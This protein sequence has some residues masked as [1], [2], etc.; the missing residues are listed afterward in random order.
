VV[1]SLERYQHLE[2]GVD[3]LV[4]AA[5]T[6]LAAAGSIQS[7]GRVTSLP[8][9]RAVRYYQTL[10]LVSRPLRYD[11]RQAVYSYRHLLELLAVKLLQARRTPL[12]L[13]QQALAGT[14]EAALEAAVADGLGLIATA[15][16][17]EGPVLDIRRAADA[18]PPGHA[19][20]AEEVW[21]GVVVT[22]DP[23]QVADPAAVLRSIRIGL[24]KRERGES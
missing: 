18:E 17:G 13:I 6:L 8:D 14:T 9:M 5:S 23:G 16:G 15:T 4:D 12:A 20:V 10:G 21:P 22:V 11:G 19:W 3:G 2:L 24:S 1:T 7:D